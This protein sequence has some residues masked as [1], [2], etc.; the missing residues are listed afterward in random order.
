[1]GK[2]NFSDDFKR[3]AVAQ[4]PGDGFLSR[5]DAL[6]SSTGDSIADDFK[7]R[8]YRFSLYIF[9]GSIQATR[10]MGRELYRQDLRWAKKPETCRTLLRKNMGL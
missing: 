2:G 9:A 3:D 5:T 8:H 7:L 1:M 10:S 6:G 4:I